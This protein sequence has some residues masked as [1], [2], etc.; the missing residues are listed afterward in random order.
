MTRGKV[1]G[2]EKGLLHSLSHTQI[3]T[4]TVDRRRTASNY[5]GGWRECDSQTYDANCD[6]LSTITPSLVASC[7]DRDCTEQLP[8]AL[9]WLCTSVNCVMTGCRRLNDWF[10]VV[11]RRLILWKLDHSSFLFWS[12]NH[13]FSFPP[14]WE[15]KYLKIPAAREMGAREWVHY[16]HHYNVDKTYTKVYYIN[17]SSWRH[18]NILPP[19]L[20]IEQ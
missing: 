7:P 20:H 14:I 9:I 17:L 12:G 19:L 8:S 10:F 6:W 13:A 11:V 1:S 5:C 18:G 3:K 16:V 4:D 15:W 2:G